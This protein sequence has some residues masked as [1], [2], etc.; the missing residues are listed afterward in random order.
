MGIL[1]LAKF[2][3]CVVST[4]VGPLIANTFLDR[5]VVAVERL[6][7]QDFNTSRL[8]VAVHV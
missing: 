6:F 1:I 4:T 5:E 8:E 2:K 7:Y 3:G